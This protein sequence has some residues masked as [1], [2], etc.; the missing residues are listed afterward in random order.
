MRADVDSIALF[1]TDNSL[2]RF[3]EKQEIEKRV[4]LKKID[5]G[6]LDIEKK[7]ESDLDKIINKYKA[8]KEN[9]LKAQKS[10]INEL[11]RGFLS[12]RPYSNVYAS[13]TAYY[14]QKDD[15]SEGYLEHYPTDETGTYVEEVEPEEFQ[16]YEDEM[17]NNE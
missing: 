14:Q 17:Q 12:F 2:R 16:G 15:Q 6:R 3:D 11:E 7:R 9:Q 8:L 4:V 10:E 1:K 5:S 13:Q